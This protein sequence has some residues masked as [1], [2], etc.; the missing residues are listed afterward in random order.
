[1][2]KTRA[3]TTSCRLLHFKV[4]KANNDEMDWTC[5]MH[6]INGNLMQDVRLKARKEVAT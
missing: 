2:R 4:I 3:K 5:S 1:M 6:G